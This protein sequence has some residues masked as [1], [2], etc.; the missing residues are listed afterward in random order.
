MQKWT[1]ILGMDPSFSNWGLAFAL[2]D[3]ITGELTIKKLEVIKPQAPKGVKLSQS[4]LD[5]L[6]S[7]YLFEN[8]HKYLH[9]VDVVCIEVPHGSNSV[10]SAVGRGVCTGVLA[11]LR[12]ST[13]TPFVLVNAFKTRKVI[14]TEG[15]VSKE[16][17]IAWATGLYPDAPWPRHNGKITNA[18]AEHMADAVTAIHACLNL[19]EFTSIK[20]RE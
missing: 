16:D 17:A 8:V 11:S 13:P 9:R 15:P 10:R 3:N 5:L 20:D 12:A 1:R 4:D 18:K 14:S 7:Q 2:M 19:P 6:R